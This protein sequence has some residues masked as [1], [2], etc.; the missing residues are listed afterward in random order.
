MSKRSTPKQTLTFGSHQAPAGVVALLK[1]R[2]LICG[3]QEADYDALFLEI[4]DEIEPITALQWLHVKNL[5]D[6]A[7]EIHRYRRLKANIINFARVDAVKAL[8]TPLVERHS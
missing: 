6:L 1:Q 4:L 5:A 8:V 2:P 3:E 7:W